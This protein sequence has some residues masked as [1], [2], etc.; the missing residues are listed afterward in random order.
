MYATWPISQS[1][2]VSQFMDVP[3]SQNSTP[4]WLRLITGITT[5]IS[6]RLR[7]ASRERRPSVP[8][9]ATRRMLGSFQSQTLQFT[10]MFGRISFTT[11]SFTLCSLRSVPRPEPR[12]QDRDSRLHGGHHLP[13]EEGGPRDPGERERG[14][15]TILPRQ[16]G[17]CR[18]H[19]VA[20]ITFC[21]LCFY[22][23]SQIHTFNPKTCRSIT[24]II[25]GTSYPGS[26]R[27]ARVSEEHS[28]VSR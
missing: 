11:G 13:G 25:R 14:D 10:D 2:Q 24:T 1:R 26:T 27:A 28:T 17:R 7:A 18:V 15:A 8:S 6:G 16:L 4:K 5:V 9:T 3:Q 22:V 19:I 20:C 23:I 12:V 21:L